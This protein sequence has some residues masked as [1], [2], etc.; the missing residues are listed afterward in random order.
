MRLNFT[1]RN[2]SVFYS[3]CAKAKLLINQHY[4]SLSRLYYRSPRRPTDEPNVRMFCVW[5]P[6]TSLVNAQADQLISLWLEQEA[7][8]Q[9]CA[10]RAAGQTRANIATHAPRKGIRSTRLTSS[11][12]PH[13]ISRC[14]AD[15]SVMLKRSCVSHRLV[16]TSSFR[17]LLKVASRSAS[18]RHWRSAS[19]ARGL[20]D[21]RRKH[22]TMC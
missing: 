3:K 7:P 21:S 4:H 12:A 9:T 1:F 17:Q 22:R 19:R 13:E 14:C 16:V 18:G 15:D 11:H 2:P 10:R 8:T 5:Q 6:S 20:S